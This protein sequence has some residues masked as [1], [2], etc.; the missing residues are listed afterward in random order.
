M[1]MITASS[2]ITYGSSYQPGGVATI[3]GGDWV[4]RLS[5]KEADVHGLGRW[6][7]CT[8]KGKDNTKLTIITAYQVCNDHIERTG[9]KTAFRQQWSLI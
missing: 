1:K 6:T 9:P 8:L 4:G 7:T 5:E 2:G 3:I